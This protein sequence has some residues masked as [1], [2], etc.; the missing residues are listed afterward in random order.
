M[1]LPSAARGVTNVVIRCEAAK[2]TGFLDLS[3]C[4]IMYIADAIYM[5]IRDSPVTK[6]SLMCN[7]MQK[8]P[9]KMVTKLPGIRW[10]NFNQNKIS[11]LPE[12]A[13]GWSLKG[14]NASA[15]Q[16]T[17]MPEV[18]FSW[19]ELNVLDF[20]DNQIKELDVERLFESLPNLKGLNLANNP[21]TSEVKERLEKLKPEQL[22]MQ[23]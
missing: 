17:A 6:V 3:D 5:I 19:S 8:F 4:Q 11:E 22:I 1:S 2:E 12:E 16:F 20:A 7:Q 13:G 15:N 18:V 21:L 9:K 10:V 23:L 14:I